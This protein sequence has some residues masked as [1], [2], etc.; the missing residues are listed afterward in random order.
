MRKTKKNW[1]HEGPRPIFIYFCYFLHRVINWHRKSSSV[2]SR[3]PSGWSHACCKSHLTSFTKDRRTSVYAQRSTIVF[4]LLV[5]HDMKSSYSSSH[6]VLS[7]VHW[8]VHPLNNS[9]WKQ[10][11]RYTSLLSLQAATHT[12]KKKKQIA[13]YR[14]KQCTHK[15]QPEFCGAKWLFVRLSYALSSVCADLLSFSYAHH[16]DLSWNSPTSLSSPPSLTHSDR[17]WDAP[18]MECCD[19]WM[20]AEV[21][22]ASTENNRQTDS[23]ENCWSE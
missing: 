22:S 13:P 1:E 4:L 7:V 9:I 11:H 21:V 19:E 17:S 2:K 6:C 18:T 20:H 12:K 16:L 8:G 3:H 23:W 5:R 10:Q 15:Q 14:S